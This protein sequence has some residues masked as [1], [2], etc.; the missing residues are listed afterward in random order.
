LNRLPGRREG[1]KGPKDMEEGG[2]GVKAER[3][4]KP[5]LSTLP[6]NNFSQAPSS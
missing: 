3:R 5:S 2:A 6:D 4:G 1:E